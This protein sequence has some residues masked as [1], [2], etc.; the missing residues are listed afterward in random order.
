M[1]LQNYRVG[2]ELF[3]AGPSTFFRGRNAVLG[4]ELLLRR[5][6][7]DPLR[8]DDVRDTFYREQRLAASLGHPNIQ[9]PIDVFEAEACLWSVH[10]MSVL[11]PTSAL[12][13]TAGPMS[14]SEAAHLG[15][16]VA[17]AL[18]HMHSRG[19]VHGK[20]SP[21]AVVRDSRGDALVINLV[22]SADLAAGIWPLRP[23]VLG[24]SPY[25]APEELEGTRPT[26]LSDLWSLAA[27]L[28][29]WLTGEPPHGG[30]TLEEQ[31]ERAR[32]GAPLLDLRERRP[33]VPALHVERLERALARDPGERRGSAAAM[34]TVL[35]EIHQRL[36]AEVPPAF[37]SGHV[38]VPRG[39]VREVEIL[40]RHGAGA[41]GVVLRARCSADGSTVA[42]KALKPEHRDDRNAYERF[43]REAR[44]MQPIR[45][46]NVVR[47]RG[48]GE[49]DGIPYAVME[50][51]SGPDLATLLL[52]EGTLPPRRAARL[53]AG[54]ARGL[55]AI[56]A[57][58]IVHRDLK[59]HNVLVG[60]GDRPVIADFGIAGNL[61]GQRLTLTGQVVGTPAYMAPE[62]FDD[63]ASTPA[64][65]LYALGAILH[66][67][68]TGQVPFPAMG[69]L[70]AIRAARETPVPPL[71]GEIPPALRDLTLRLL[72]KRP[73]NRPASAAE[74]AEA[75][76]AWLG[77]AS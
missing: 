40:G 10:E 44:A 23:A 60:A 33:D 19:F 72:A 7:I 3:R 5:L 1:R 29:F 65:D 34:A 59:P 58:G 4:H 8:A 13:A 14:T 50:F 25:T 57:E 32:E 63:V 62:T 54:I 77:E 45:H 16:Q 70:E 28:V 38:L 47:I 31:L 69:A 27:T 53:G 61:T 6:D 46:P 75:L 22:K 9:R 66:E 35:T 68:L 36:A 51:V 67:L 43:L 39:D 37:R 18:A 2:A 49:R 76:E 21:E 15:A 74:V 11:E 42:V 12:V 56:H 55:E 20:L 64:A 26:A 71:P 17:D 30:A 48:V 73:E 24:I 41:F 52:R